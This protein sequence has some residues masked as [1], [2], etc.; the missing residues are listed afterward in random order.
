VP[1]PEGLSPAQHEDRRVRLG[2]SKRRYAETIGMAQATYINRTFYV[3][4]NAVGRGAE[5]VKRVR[6]WRERQE[7]ERREMRDRLTE[8]LEAIERRAVEIREL[9]DELDNETVPR[10]R[11]ARSR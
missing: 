4:P 7:A 6:D 9:I 1:F 3:N 5:V 11:G 2:L 8:E 10:Q